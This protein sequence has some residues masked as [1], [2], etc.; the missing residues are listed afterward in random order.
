MQ[1]GNLK[2]LSAARILA[3]HEVIPPQQ[4]GP[5]LLISRPVPLVRIPSERPLLGALEPSDLIGASL[6]AEQA[7]EI[8]RFQNFFFVEKVSLF[9][10]VDILPRIPNSHR[11]ICI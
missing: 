10:E 2:P 1:A 6:A 7:G 3:L 8:G 4:I 5:R 11:K 9:H